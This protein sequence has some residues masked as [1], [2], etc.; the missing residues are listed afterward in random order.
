M[1]IQKRKEGDW[2]VVSVSGRLD[3]SQ[4]GYLQTELEESVRCGEL[5]IRL[6]LRD[7]NFLSS[8]GIRVLLIYFK[9]LKKLGGCFAIAEP[10]HQVKTVLDLT[11]LS[12]M[13]AVEQTVED[14]K[15]E[16]ISKE[17]GFE[18]CGWK[19]LEGLLY[20][21]DPKAALS[22]RP[23]GKPD[24]LVHAAFGPQDCV[25][26]HAAKNMAG[27][28]LGAFGSGFED[29][30]DRFGEFLAAAG[31]AVYL[32]AGGAPIPDYMLTQGA[33]IPEIRTLYA[34]VLE[35]AFARFLRFETCPDKLFV[36]LSN[37][38][39]ALFEMEKTHTIGWV[40][41]AE[42]SGLIGASLKQSPARGGSAD[43]VFAH[44]G[45]REWISFTPEYA[46]ARSMVLAVGI[47]TSAAGTEISPF[48]RPLVK[49]GN[50][51]AHVHAAA[52]D[53]L[54]LPKGLLTVEETTAS[55]F[56]DGK[57]LGLLHLI[58]DDR[59]FIGSGESIFTRGAV[60]FA[61]VNGIKRL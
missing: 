15:P 17:T 12:G 30:R 49:G 22:C 32:P 23:V 11:G 58:G 41:V 57:I 25:T 5:R 6:V 44:P 43:P 38:V 53:F 21:L 24:R 27:L 33:M 46:Y 60:W 8:A 48:V 61:P 26:L 47:A 7:V 40:M 45:V 42:T 39:E 3:S 55:L 19:A 59:E 35:G 56:R 1:E 29:T 54:A 18:R 31:S 2:L 16:T 37:I 51:A 14:R 13:L 34:L 4:A 10:S 50:I 9:M 20:R 28:G 52:F 36:P